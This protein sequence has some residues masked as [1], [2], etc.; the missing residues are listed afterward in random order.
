M[1]L[2]DIKV[3]TDLFIE[4]FQPIRPADP[5]E[6]LTIVDDRAKAESSHVSALSVQGKNESDGLCFDSRQRLHG[7]G[8]PLS[9]PGGLEVFMKFPNHL[10]PQV[11][12]SVA[13]MS[14]EF[15]EDV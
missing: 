14:I 3:I 10:S 13:Y 7:Y 8:D 6:Y 1:M 4:N 2:R 5:V 12:S 15:G 11:A 9:T